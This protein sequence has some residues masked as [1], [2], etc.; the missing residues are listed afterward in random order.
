MVKFTTFELKPDDGF[1][2][3]TDATPAEA[4]AA[5][6]I[7]AVNCVELMNVVWRAN[8]PKLTADPETK[9]APFTV[10]VK[11]A[12][13]AGVLFGEIADTAGIG[14]GAGSFGS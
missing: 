12:P 2:T 6:G 11:S 4:I 5:A 9:L 1:V 14:S 10:S 8:P 3:I 7:A 13:P